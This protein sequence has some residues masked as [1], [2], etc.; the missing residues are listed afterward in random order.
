MPGRE[1]EECGKD[2]HDRCIR[3]VLII[4]LY[5]PLMFLMPQAVPGDYSGRFQ[6]NHKSNIIIIIEILQAQI[7]GP[8]YERGNC[9]QDM[10]GAADGVQFRCLF[11]LETARFPS[12]TYTWL[13]ALASVRLVRRTDN[14]ETKN[15][16]G[17][18]QPER[19][20]PAPGV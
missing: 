14:S 11:L 16:C 10:A 18:Q 4:L 15:R 6:Y 1:K 20:W 17:L 19:S 8:R 3:S 2:A 5:Q 12:T 13:F 7:V 9:Q